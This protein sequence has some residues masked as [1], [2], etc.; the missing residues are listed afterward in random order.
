M[1]AHDGG[2]E[3]LKEM[4]RGTHGR[5]RVEEGLE[6]ASLAQA[7]EALPDAVP[8]AKFAWQGTP[9]Y[10]VDRE[11]VH[12]LQE[13]TVVVPRLSTPRLRDIKHFQN[14]CPIALHHSRQHVRLPVAGHAVIRTKPDSGIRQKRMA[15]IP[16]TQPRLGS[17]L[18]ATRESS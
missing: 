3:H 5:E 10:V 2:V 9:R 13:L 11:V 14:D 7:I 4:R 1:S 18:I 6:D 15:G 8:I 17:F 16:S 12:R